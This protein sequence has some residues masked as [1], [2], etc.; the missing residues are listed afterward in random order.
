MEFMPNQ[1]P[2]RFRPD[3][4]SCV[5][6]KDF[7]RLLLE[8]DEQITL[9]TGAGAEYDVVGKSWGFYA[10]PSLNGRL[11]QFGLRP[12]LVRNASRKYFVLLV[13]KG[14]AEAFE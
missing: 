9:C 3:S 5:E 8:P 6:L 4:G 14:R 1:P 10:T 7:G 12:A 2:R 11:R 13:E